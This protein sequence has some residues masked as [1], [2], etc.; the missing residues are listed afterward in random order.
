MADIV[1]INPRFE[2]S[3]WGMEH[4]LPF[5][6]KSSNLPVASLPLLAALTPAEHS[7]TLIDE[8]IE[9]IDW[10]RVAR[11]DIVGV[12]GMS[13]QRFRMMEII[14]EL[15]ERGC[16]V[17]VGGPWVTVQED[18]FEGLADVIFI[19]EADESWPRFLG[20][21]KQG[22]HQYRYEQAEKTDMTKVPTPR[23]DMLKM[24]RYAF[25]SLQFS[26]GCPFQCEFCD[27]IVTFG[28][29]PRI[30]TAAQVI[31]EFEAM[32]ASGQRIVF[33]VDDNLIGNK[34]AI[35]EVLREVVAWQ[36][37]KGYPLSLFTEA[38]IDLADDPELL[39]LMTRANFVAT[40]IGIESPSEEAHREAKKFQNVRAGGTLIEKVH[41]IQEAGL[42]VWCG[43]IM[44]FDSDDAT[45]FDRQIEFI[46]ACRIPFAMTGMLSA[47]PKTPLHDRL[48]AEGR[49]DLGDRPE[50]GTNVI[51]LQ[52]TREELLDGYLRVIGD[53]Y[54]PELYFER[55]DALFLDPA[56]DFGITK[57][58]PW[59]RISLR[60][61]QME[62]AHAAMAAGLFGRLMAHVP[63]AGL[64]AVYRRHLGRFLKVHRRPGL[65]FTYVFH[66][67][68]HFHVWKLGKEM[69]TRESQ[70][71]NSF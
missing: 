1:I 11:A 65:V 51:P 17:V 22:L 30:K 70:L 67:A 39:D 4:A 6:G 47:I 24:G 5:L 43:M 66:M 2:K 16:F 18:Y 48:A 50:F 3:Y 10:D 12:T 21:W 36:E 40:F 8:S 9:E 20:E 14:R 26:R 68:M 55:T 61:W 46:Q 34:K 45:I 28:R 19:G 37:R 7:V 58:K 52:M 29:R 38:S 64:R 33:V 62:A 54:D 56:F 44:G 23:F 15:K 49:L 59:W 13:V 69:A 60:W 41:R 71:V 57:R 42:E 32:Y 27:I 35:K 63:D 31:A 25:G 53:L